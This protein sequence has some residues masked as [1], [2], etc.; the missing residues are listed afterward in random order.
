M[1]CTFGHGWFEFIM[2]IHFVLRYVIFL[3]ISST[4]CF[5]FCR[6]VR[7]VMWYIFEIFGE[8]IDPTSRVMWVSACT[9]LQ[10][11]SIIWYTHLVWYDPLCTKTQLPLPGTLLVVLVLGMLTTW[12]QC[13]TTHLFTV[14]IS[15][16]YEGTRCVYCV[17]VLIVVLTIILYIVLY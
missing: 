6:W 15:F 10:L 11:C 8:P 17:S 9:F 3:W 1:H 16:L 2:C 7:C 5:D 14:H 4:I 13:C 12:Y